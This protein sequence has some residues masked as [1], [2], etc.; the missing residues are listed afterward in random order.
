M[1]K[2]RECFMC[3]MLLTVLDVKRVGLTVKG[4]DPE[5]VEVCGRCGTRVALAG[6]MATSRDGLTVVLRPLPVQDELFPKSSRSSPPA[7]GYHV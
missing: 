4:K 1:G 7:G 5:T 2:G 3:C 6:A